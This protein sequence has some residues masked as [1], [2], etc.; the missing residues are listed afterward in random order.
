M[1]LLLPLVFCA[2][3]RADDLPAT[4]DDAIKRLDKALPLR[5]EK[6]ARR[7][8]RIDSMRDVVESVGGVKNADLS[9]VENI[10]VEYSSL[11]IVSAL[12]VVDSGD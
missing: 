2:V 12:S 6:V 11:S 1:S 9:F 3:C 7:F 8:A 5:Y 10:G 4:L